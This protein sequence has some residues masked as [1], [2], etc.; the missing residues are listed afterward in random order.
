MTSELV[1]TAPAGLQVISNGR[2]VSHAGRVWHWKLDRTH[3]SYLITLVVGRFDKLEETWGKV[4]IRSFFPAGRKAEGKN[5]FVRTGKMMQFFSELVGRYPWPHY[6]QIVVHDFIYGG[7]GNTGATTLNDR[8]LHDDRAR[9]DY[10]ADGLVAHE[11]AHQWF[12]DVV[13][14]QTFEHL[15][16][17]EG[18][19]TYM[20]ELWADKHLGRD[21]FLI[22]RR[23]SVRGVIGRSPIPKKFKF[24]RGM[25]SGLSG[26][27][28]Y[29]RGA[30]VLHLLRKTL[31]DAAFFKAVKDYVAANSD[32]S[33]ETETFRKALEASSGKQL[34]RFFDDWVYHPGVPKLRFFWSYS[35][36]RKAVLV[37]ATQLQ[38][39]RTYQLDI[40]VLLMDKVGNTRP[41]ADRSRAGGRPSRRRWRRRRR[42]RKTRHHGGDGQAT[43]RRGRVRDQLDPY[44]VTVEVRGRVA[45]LAELDRVERLHGVVGQGRDPQ[46]RR[47]PGFRR[48]TE[49]D[50]VE[51]Q[52]DPLTR[53][54]R[55]RLRSNTGRRERVVLRTSPELTATGTAT[56]SSGLVCAVTLTETAAQDGDG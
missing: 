3:V 26:G 12:G 21:S 52:P 32:R 51:G 5:A 20:A 40:P 56:W 2:L 8:A 13:T 42:R 50:V 34:G 38:T 11:L 6:D 28:A 22:N 10:S 19:A 4:R 35:A 7:M 31:G 15:W 54:A 49:H 37:A 33:I 25:P 53:R 41:D 1:V 55:A 46:D 43:R 48:R 30:A 29:S 39:H 45:P 47:L 36:E 16:L 18:F 44:G 14:C 23:R 17:N 9:L 24:R 27:A